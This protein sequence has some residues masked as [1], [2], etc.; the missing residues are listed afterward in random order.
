MFEDRI[1]ARTERR[2]LVGSWEEIEA[3]KA[4]LDKEGWV[5]T[6]QGWYTDVR[7]WADCAGN[8]RWRL[9]VERG[10]AGSGNE[11]QRIT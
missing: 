8:G 6:F 2:E 10:I 7:D 1:V 3:A 9:V 11:R 4:Q 5:I